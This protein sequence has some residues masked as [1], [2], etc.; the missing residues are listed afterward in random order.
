MVGKSNTERTNSSSYNIKNLSRHDLSSNYNHINLNKNNFNRTYTNKVNGIY[1]LNNLIRLNFKVTDNN[2]IKNFSMFNNF[3][4]NNIN[5][6]NTNKKLSNQT[7]DHNKSKNNVTGDPV[8][9]IEDRK[10][11]EN[12]KLFYETYNRKTLLNLHKEDVNNLSNFSTIDNPCEFNFSKKRG[13]IE[14]FNSLKRKKHFV[15]YFLKIAQY[16]SRR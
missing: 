7:I 14:N 3:T 15:N 12:K 13:S 6:K 11:S 4:K 5:N 9:C 8:K 1:G 2:E 16:K 10:K